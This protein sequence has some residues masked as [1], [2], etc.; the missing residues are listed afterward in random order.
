MVVGVTRHLGSRL[1]KLLADD[2]R[3][4]HVVGVDAQEPDEST[5]IGAAEFV[6]ADIRTSG[7]AQAI[8]RARADTV[9][10]MNVLAARGDAGGRAPQ[11][12]INVI[13][14]MQLLGACQRSDTVAKLI[15]KSSAAVYGT[16]ANAP[17]MYAEDMVPSSPSRRGYEKDASEVEGYVR[18]F[19]RRR[20][21]IDVTILRMANV[22][23]PSITTP[24]SSYF[25]LP[26]VPVPLGRDPR[27]QLLHEDDCLE[28]LRLAA[29]EDRPGIY[30]VA[31]RGF[32]SL[33]QALARAGRIPLP[34]PSLGHPLVHGTLRRTGLAAIDPSLARFL[35]YG[36]GIDTSRMTKQLGFEPAHTSI[37]AFDA[38]VQAGAPGVLAPERIQRFTDTIRHAIAGV[39]RR[40]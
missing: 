31:G 22:I 36:R 37:Q 27:F 5:D 21:D 32:L 39:D 24:L 11:K 4:D 14:T 18:G 15:V 8:K 29:V 30:N 20:P 33:L 38:H 16:G 40:G 1:A 2:P 17:A 26:A 35:T 13:G 12:E 25:S 23:G 10:H 3:V 7:I 28:A 19:N 6:Q 9:I 34:V